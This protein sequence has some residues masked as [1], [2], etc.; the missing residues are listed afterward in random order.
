[1]AICGL[2]LGVSGLGNL[3]Q[4]YAP[5]LQWLCM[6]I[7]GVLWLLVLCK[8]V[9]DWPHTRR[10]LEDPLALSVS[11]AF[12]MTLL[13][14]CI[15]LSG[16]ARPLALLLWTIANLGHIALLF[17]FS[18]RF[19][20]HFQLSNVYATWNVLY[21]GNMLA[22]VAAPLLQSAPAAQAAPWIF[23]IGLILFL[24]W[25]PVSA[26]RYWKL[27]VEESAAPTICILAAPFHLLLAGY[28]SSAPE[29]QTVPAILCCI[30]AQS[31]YLFVLSRLPRIL[32]RP[33]Y[34]SFSAMTFPFVISATALGRL[35]DL[36][37][38]RGIAFPS[39][40]YLVLHAE[41]LIAA[42]M[43]TYVLCRYLR[44]LWERLDASR[45]V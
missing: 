4:V 9:S 2:S 41:E 44:F 14:F 7:A 29:P 20:R 43:V 33:F 22:A 5:V 27:P 30:F 18:R 28:L 12:F 25:Y 17:V 15:A 37:S 36:L 38:A 34:P 21:G 8:A 24:P 1:M 40:L 6:G 42:A 23:W 11:E 26:Y 13:Q 35:L 19:L 32:W 39:L 16:C 3:L 31:M 45:S 10:E